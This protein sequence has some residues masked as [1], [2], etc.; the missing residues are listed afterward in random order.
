MAPI[1]NNILRGVFEGDWVQ[2]PFGAVGFDVVDDEGVAA[3]VVRLP[4]EDLLR[5]GSPEAVLARLAFVFDGPV[6]KN[7][8]HCYD[9]FFIFQPF[10]EGKF[11]Q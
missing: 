10:W 4:P 5:V 1:G 11:H 3:G 7:A 8:S 9:T 2:A 6:R